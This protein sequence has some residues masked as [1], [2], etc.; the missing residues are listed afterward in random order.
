MFRLQPTERKHRAMNWVTLILLNFGA[1][2]LESRTPLSL[3][4]TNDIRIRLYTICWSDV[5]AQGLA[6]N[7]PG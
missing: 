2:I 5:S 4:T 6:F 3:Q 1:N 7:T